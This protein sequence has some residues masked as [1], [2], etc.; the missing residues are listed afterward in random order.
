MNDTILSMNFSHYEL[1]S[2]PLVLFLRLLVRD[3]IDTCIL[4][5]VFAKT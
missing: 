2:L 5:M 4:I 1:F 3:S